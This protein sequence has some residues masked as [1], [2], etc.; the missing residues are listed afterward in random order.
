MAI[1]VSV[2]PGPFDAGHELARL[3]AGRADIGA[4]ASFIGL[5]RADDG[6]TALTLEHHPTMT[7]R[8]LEAIART[9]GD[10]F[11][12]LGGTII[13]RHGRL[14]PGEAIVLVAVSSIHRGAAFSACEFLMDW[15]KTR[16]PFWKLEEGNW[17]KRWVDAKPDDDAAAE[18]W[19]R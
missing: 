15:L 3:G 11:P 9:A 18:R 4:V 16:A 19:A 2:Q 14:L 8:Q 10:R 1:A 13:H 7:I 17:G 6:L 12:L 5:V